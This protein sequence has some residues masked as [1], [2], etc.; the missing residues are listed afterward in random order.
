MRLRARSWVLMVLTGALVALAAPAA[1]QAAGFGFA[2][3]F[4][5]NCSAGHETCGAG[6]KEG[7]KKEAEEEGYRQAGGYTPF[8]VSDFILNTVEPEPGLKVP[9][10]NLTSLRVDVAPGLVT[11]PNNVPLCSM[12]DFTSTEVEPV[13]HF[14]LA[15]K[16]ATSS[17][18]GENKVIQV[19]E[20][21][22]GSHKFVDAP[23]AGKVYNVEPPVGFGSDYGVAIEVAAGVFAHTFIEGNVE[24]GSDYHDYYLI[25]N[26]G[27]GLIESR[28]VFKGRENEAHEQ[29]GFI[30]NPSACSEAGPSTTTTV[31]GE[32]E[33]GATAS[34]PYTDPVGTNN[35]EAEG[36]GPFLTLTPETTVSDAPDGLS[37]EVTSPHNTKELSATDNSDLKT[38]T[39]TLPEGL[40]MN[41]S[42]GAGLAGCTPEQIGIGTR[43]S[44]TC[45]S[46]SKIGTVNLEVPTLPPGA[47]QGPIF[48]GKPAGAQITGPP[49]TIY[50]DAES[51]RYGVKVRIKGTVTP[52]PV[53]GRLTTT[54]TENPEASFNK[55]I[56]HFNGGAFAALANPLVCEVGKSATSFTGFSG[57]GPLNSEIPFAT[58][59]CSSSPPPFS[60]TQSTSNE[61]GKGGAGNTF[62][63]VLERPEGN[64]Y[65][66]KI[67]VVLPK[68]LVGLIPTVTQ[69]EEAAAVAGTCTSASQI[70]T[71]AVAAGSGSPFTFHGNTYLTGPYQGAPF[72]LEFVVFPTAG[73]FTLPP[74]IARAKIEVNPET[75]Q[76]IATDN[77]VPTIVGGIPTR[78]RSL[79]V[80][81]NRQGFEVNPT[82]C[83][84][85][86]TVSTLT[87]TLGALATVST[88]F[89]AEG[90][91]SLA[92]KPAFSAAGGA[93]FSR[94]NGASLETT[95]NMPSGGANV[96]SVKV[97]LP[98]ALPSRLTTLQKS[99]PEA[100][101]NANPLTCPAGSFVG[102]VRA[103]TPTLPA[104]MKG[105]AILVSHGGRSFP[106]LD[107]I[108]EGNGVRVI[109]VGNTDIKKGITTTTFATTPDVPVSSITVNLPI[110]PHSALAAFGDLCRSPLFMPTEM[111]G[112]NGKLVK[113]NTRINV[114]GCGVKV[115]GRKVIGNTAYLTV[116][117]FGKGR[118]TGSGSG[119]S[120]RSRTFNSTQNGAALNLPLSGS[121]RRPFTAKIRVS[122]HSNQRGVPN[123]STTVSVRFP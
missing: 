33:G 38:A 95:L 65:V 66:G 72:G 86:Q 24:W 3:L 96:K 32:S 53:T 51:A 82:N 79:T 12:K 34:R 19:V 75:A 50:F 67:K 91:G 58:G 26:I 69:C 29:T 118:I 76:V 36:F 114:K 10:E 63:Q 14:F 11:N 55:V 39:I 6:A 102:G 1:A 93:N 78:M 64:Q 87:S 99:C 123:S 115:V 9:D 41:P 112:Q 117:T 25:K 31:S 23:L 35:C 20:F 45:P 28:L 121:R 103:N 4:A 80:S 113:Q 98:A 68:G 104:K 116:K 110:G 106:D 70:G 122:F 22:E 97:T 62:T 21:P 27:P 37:F 92:F 5:G 81:I 54:F 18:I 56:L 59:G 109:L 2:K 13:R 111:T 17:I 100:T 119:V 84:V 49:Y 77:E 101:F 52:N 48:L 57:S 94:Q 74:V 108:L 8:G 61:P 90:C 7:T 83:D 73:P 44:V 40:T 43:N 107:L 42:A 120:S 16:C 88:P 47:L 105:P 30:R 89:Q 46:G 15:P 60:P 85:Q 71:V